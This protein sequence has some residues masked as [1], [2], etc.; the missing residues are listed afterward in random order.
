MELADR[1]ALVTGAN[2]GLG[3]AMAT[4]LAEAGAAVALHYR[5]NQQAVDALA[6]SLR[7]AGH[8]VHV[9]QGD[10][11]TAA[12]TRQV[13]DA[14]LAQLGQV[15][16]LIN[17]AGDWVDKPLLQ[18]SD[19]EWDRLIDVDLRAPY[20]LTR[21]LAP[22]MVTRG[23]GRIVNISS[24]ASLGYVPGEGLYGIA[25][26]GINALTHAAGVELA[27]HGVTVN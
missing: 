5:S 24:V 2:S 23:W 21:L 1:R 14:A 25:K 20:L 16:I 4:M 7:G 26:A 9:I 13:A 6:A 3:Q 11:S 27:P 15:D 22:G 19:A 12:A 10:L 17:N 8:T 18:T